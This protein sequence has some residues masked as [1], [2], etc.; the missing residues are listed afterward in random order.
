MALV[1]HVLETKGTAVWTI[2]KDR[3]ARDA[4]RLMH[5]RH[6]GSVIVMSGDI[7]LGIFTERDLMNRVVAEDRDPKSTRVADVMTGRIAICSRDT[8]LEACRSA[9]TRNKIRHLPVVEDGKL[10]GIISSGDILAR[11]LKDQEETIRYL[12]EYMLGPN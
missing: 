7:I 2:D 5:E 3:T 12:H 6:I 11:E 9:M 1:Q 8:T 10:L 4:A